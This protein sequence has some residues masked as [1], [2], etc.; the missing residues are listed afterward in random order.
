MGLDLNIITIFS[1]PSHPFL[2]LTLWCSFFFTE[3]FVPFFIILF[4]LFCKLHLSPFK[5]KRKL[6]ICKVIFV[7]LLAS[8]DF[9][10]F[11]VVCKGN[12]IPIES[13]WGHYVCYLS[14]MLSLLN[15][16]YV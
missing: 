7:F 10:K 14:K 8:G 1:C 16:D 6:Y 5:R 4:Y 12:I 3:I 11:F 13:L 9:D 15:V 2:Y